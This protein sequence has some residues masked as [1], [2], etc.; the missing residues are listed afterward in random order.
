MISLSL[1]KVAIEYNLQP[2]E[3]K[4]LAKTLHINTCHKDIALISKNST[5]TLIRSLFDTRLYVHFRWNDVIATILLCKAEMRS[6]Y[7]TF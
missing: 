3:N 7:V 1:C 5:K 4:V 6:R 2:I